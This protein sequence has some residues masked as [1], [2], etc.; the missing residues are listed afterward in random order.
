MTFCK[1][2]VHGLTNDISY[3]VK[4]KSSKIWFLGGKIVKIMCKK[5]E[6]LE[7]ICSIHICWHIGIKFCTV[8]VHILNKDIIYDTMLKKS[9]NLPFLGKIFKFSDELVIFIKMTP[10]FLITVSNAN[11]WPYTSTGPVWKLRIDQVNDMHCDF[12]SGVYCVSEM[13]S[14]TPGQNWPIS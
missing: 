9:K 13:E 11:E 2:I 1:V 10:R 12:L 14:W 5:R 8:V 7:N 6:K 3:D 4:L